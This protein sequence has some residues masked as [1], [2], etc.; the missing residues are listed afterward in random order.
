MQLLHLKWSIRAVHPGQLALLGAKCIIV[1]F[2][3]SLYVMSYRGSVWSKQVPCGDLWGNDLHFLKNDWLNGNLQFKNK[4]MF[5][6]RAK[7]CLRQG[8]KYM[9]VL[10]LSG[11]KIPF[12]WSSSFFFFFPPFWHLSFALGWWAVLLLFCSVVVIFIYCEV[13]G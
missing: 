4:G 13:Y 1:V 12:L 10:C 8:M 3:L 7:E 11:L 6:T 2:I 5:R 9:T